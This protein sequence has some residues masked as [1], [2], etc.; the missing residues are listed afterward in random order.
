VRELRVRK[1][2][3]FDTICFHTQQCAEKYVKARLVEADI[4][5]PKIHAL[6]P[7]LNLA[8]PLEPAWELFREDL[9]KLTVFGI[10]FRYPG[11]SA[12]RET[13]E[14]A[15]KRCRRFRKAARVALGLSGK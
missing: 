10:A 7:L 11:E 5:F 1:H 14:D 3:A 8:L 9:A 4:P 15:V 12:D 2:A 6:I 13:A